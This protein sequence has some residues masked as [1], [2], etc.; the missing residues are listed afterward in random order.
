MGILS[1]EFYKEEVPKGKQR[2]NA[3]LGAAGYK[4]LFSSLGSHY[5]IRSLLFS[6]VKRYIWLRLS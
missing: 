6:F 5:S 2:S 1:W 4:C 3:G